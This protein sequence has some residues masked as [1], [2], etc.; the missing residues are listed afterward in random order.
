MGKV[1]FVFPGQGSQSI[2]MGKDLYESSQAARNIFERFN[3]VLGRDIT[4]ICFEGPEEALKQ[5]INTQPA[6]LAV[7]I[8]AYEALIEK[9]GF[10][11]N[12]VAGHSLGEY[13]ALYASG[14]LNL[15]N[16]IK[17]IAK[18]AEVMSEAKSG[19]MSAILGIEDDKLEQA[20]KESSAFGIV[21]V[22]N[23]NT[24][25]QTVITGET[26]AIEKANELCS[27]YGAKRVIPLA[28]SGAFHS[29]LMKEPADKFA[30]YL[31]QFDLNDAKMPVITNVDSKETI[32]KLEI[33]EKMV[34]QIYSSVMWKQTVAYMVSQ[35]VET[36]VEIGPGKV[37]SGMNRKIGK[38]LVS[39]NILDA[40][41]L[42]K[43]VET[44][45][46]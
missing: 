24:P 14:V 45:G 13:G 38:D 41:S 29:P 27:Q 46:Q 34:K 15:D 42:S 17:L 39:L 30:E 19:A 32:D 22:A 6:I 28:V 2:G 25:D 9:T 11:P 31:A 16:T 37:L 43:V 8:A 36:L 44:L 35:G 12:Y 4:K 10:K 26:A 23:Y 33:K 40:E 5:T 3:E 7:S 21:A 1:G 18:R 20:V